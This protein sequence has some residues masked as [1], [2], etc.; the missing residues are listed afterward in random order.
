M[1]RKLNCVKC[2]KVYTCFKGVYKY[3]KYKCGNCDKRCPIPTETR[4]E[5]DSETKNILSEMQTNKE[6]K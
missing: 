5:C 3:Q 1:E 6:A 2:Q 4:G